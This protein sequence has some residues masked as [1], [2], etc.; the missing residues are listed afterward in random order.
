LLHGVFIAFSSAAAAVLMPRS[1]SLIILS[2]K[3]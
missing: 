1:P 3:R 2:S